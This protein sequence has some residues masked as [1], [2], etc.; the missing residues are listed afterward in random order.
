MTYFVLF[1]LLTFNKQ[2]D[3]GGPL[4]NLVDDYFEEI[5]IV[6]WGIGCAERQYPGVYTRVTAY[7]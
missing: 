6:S 2:G 7:T 4:M 1:I 5:G 3:S